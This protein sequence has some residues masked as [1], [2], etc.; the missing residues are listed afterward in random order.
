MSTAEQGTRAAQPVFEI[1]ASL[2]NAEDVVFMADHTKLGHKASFFFGGIQDLDCVIT[3][4]AAAP[5]ILEEIRQ[6]G[7]E[8]LVGG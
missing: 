5:E 8:V 7:V 4:A 6:Q 3:D 2:A 1:R